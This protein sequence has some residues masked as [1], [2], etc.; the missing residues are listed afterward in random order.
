LAET[1]RTDDSYS[2]RTSVAD[3]VSRDSDEFEENIVQPC[4]AEFTFEGK[5]DQESGIFGDWIVTL[6]ARLYMNEYDVEPVS[7][8]S[9]TWEFTLGEPET[10]FEAVFEEDEPEERS[11]TVVTFKEKARYR[12]TGTTNEAGPYPGFDGEEVFGF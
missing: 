4:F 11:E 9:Q 2:L 10:D 5:L 7:V 8:P 6:G 12:L 3:Y 1:A